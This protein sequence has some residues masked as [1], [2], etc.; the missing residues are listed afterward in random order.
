MATESPPRP[1]YVRQPE[2]VGDTP[3]QND[4]FN[5]GAL[6]ASLTSFIDR[7]KDGC[8]I[9]LDA[10][11][12]EGKTWFG[13]NWQ[14]KL[15]ADGYQTIYLDAFEQDYSED[16]FTVLAAEILQALAA[17]SDK[18]NLEKLRAAS[19]KL[20]KT[21]L[22]AAAKI[23][24]N[25][26]GKL[27]LGTQDLAGE[28]TDAI[29]KLDEKIADAAEKYIAAR[30]SQ[31][32]AEK[33]SVAGFRAALT[34]FAAAQDK[35]VVFFIDELDRCRPDFAVRIVE[36]VKHFFDVPNLVFVLLLNREQL[37]RAIEGVY[38]HGFDANAYLGKFIHLFLTLPKRKSLDTGQSNAAWVYA[39]QVGK[40]YRFHESRDFE[41]FVNA[42][43]QLSAALDL[44]LRDVEKAIAL[45]ALT[46]NNSQ[47]M[48]Y[49][50]WPIVLKLR[51]PYI[52]RGLLSTNRESHLR[53][54]ELLN[55]IDAGDTHFWIRDYYLAL[56]SEIAHGREHLT[57]AQRM[58]LE[59]Y[60]PRGFHVGDIFSSF[61]KRIDV[62][63]L[64]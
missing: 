55:T 44:S 17:K 16:P 3:F 18:S 6:A 50:A 60:S 12:G 49:L 1:L 39:W 9:G 54:L 28:V 59:K 14:A 36:R 21:L 40:R 47:S 32:D 64:D 20:G 51:Y 19:V 15:D 56:H 62:A 2:Y 38:G 13:R 57:D 34:E 10:P 61:L 43:G 46:G 31:S 42:F 29:G 52:Y 25:T 58:H 5:R 22:P 23:S 63:L 41:V 24:I 30:L 37:W 35:P 26:V 8:V 11:W 4:L 33:K 27:L 45:L 53:A 48:H 7:G